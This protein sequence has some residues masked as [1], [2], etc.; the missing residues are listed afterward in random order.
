MDKFDKYIKSEIEQLESPVSSDMW[1]RIEAQLD[2]VTD[3]KRHGAFYYWTIGLMSLLTLAGIYYFYN[4][5][6]NSNILHSNTTIN[7]QNVEQTTTF[8]E[9][10]KSTI[11]SND[12][13]DNDK[14]ESN[15]IAKTNSDSKSINKNLGSIVDPSLKTP[16]VKEIRTI[17][18]IEN[19]PNQVSAK[20]NKVSANSYSI[21]HSVIGQKSTLI[22]K[23]I[24][25]N[26][27]NSLMNPSSILDKT[28]DMSSLAMFSSIKLDTNKSLERL[29]NMKLSDISLLEMKY[30][31]LDNEKILLEEVITN[32][33]CPDLREAGDEHFFFEAHITPI[34]NSIMMRAKTEE[35]YSYLESRRYSETPMLSYSLGFRAGFKNSNGIIFSTGL[36]YTQ[37]NSSLNHI[38]SFAIR[39]RTVYDTLIKSD[40]TIEV[41][42]KHYTIYG[43]NEIHANN[44]MSMIDIPLLFSYEFPVT[45]RLNINLTSG[46]FLNLNFA[47]E[48]R[49]LNPLGVPEWTSSSTDDTYH[50]YKNSLGVSMH[51]AVGINYSISNNMSILLYPNARLYSKSFTIGKYPLTEHHLLYGLRTGV[52]YLF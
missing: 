13:V 31:Q 19:K 23:P 1:N 46:V 27:E 49:I 28:S 37:L 52:R 22:S 14:V 40:G 17:N 20:P 4:F 35:Y 33:D 43:T 10:E 9:S 5:N 25:S 15:D 50:V 24:S 2:V 26:G 11:Q 3:S 39:K 42:V 7:K 48:S 51:L 30:F 44:Y 36:D 32:P 6:A 16:M 34:I 47:H 21:V 18:E 12:K 41:E 38:D 45:E 29:R 8:D